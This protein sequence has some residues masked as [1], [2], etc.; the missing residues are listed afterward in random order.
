MAAEPADPAPALNGVIVP[1]T[2]FAQNCS[3]VWCTATMRGAV[4]DPGGELDVVLEAAREQGVTIEKIL[5][6]HGHLDHAGATADLRER[7]GVPVEG[8][9]R[10]DAFWIDQLAAQG[11]RYGMAWCRAFTPDRWLAD[12]DAVALGEQ[13]LEVLHCPGHTPGHI[14]FFHRGARLALVGDVLFQGSI[15]RTDL[16]RG[17]HATLI[18]SIT[19]KLWPLGEDV[20][21]VPGHGPLSTFG[22]ERA[23]NPYVA[24][25]VLRG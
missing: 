16:P 18:R 4:V 17:D 11:A 5:L 14:V 23:S 12:G 13:R 9:E 3:I 8:P 21:F 25:A 2:P 10:A 20:A 15:G 24:D 6:T 22:A 7:L 19:T 1:V